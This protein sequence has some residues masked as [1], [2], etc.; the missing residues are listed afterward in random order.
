MTQRAQDGEADHC[1]E[2]GF[3]LVELLVA[4]A[5]LS[6]LSLALF[7][8]LRFGLN[9]WR[10]GTDHADRAQHSMVV[11]SFLRRTIGDAYPFLL[12]P[13]DPNRARV[14]FTGTARSLSFLA[15][16]P[17]ALGTGGRLRFVL[18]I[19]RHGEQNDVVMTSKAELV[20]REDATTVTRKALLADVAAIELAYFGKRRADRNAQWH[21]SWQAET[22]LPQLVRLRVQFFANDAREWQDL[23]IA[24]RINA[25]VGCIYD[26]L[27]KQCR[28][29][30]APRGDPL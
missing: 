3:T 10:L 5:L 27:T 2:A 28:G 23:L 25:D 21:D 29:R 11:Q 20:E 17:I 8:S 14:D 7:G 26:L 16:A 4:F 15:T 1:R 22:A 9:A 30:Q 13:T 18:A 24:P 12:L 19:E 6:V